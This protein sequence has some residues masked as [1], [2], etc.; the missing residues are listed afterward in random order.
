[1]R[2]LSAVITII[3][4]AW[5]GLCTQG[6][7]FL[8][9]HADVPLPVVTPR[10]RALHDAS[11]IIDLHADSLLMR[12]DLLARS[13]KGH[14]DLPRLHEGGVA[15]QVFAAPT[16]TPWNA[17]FD[18]TDGDAFDAIRLVGILQWTPLAWRRPLGRALWMAEKL[19]G[20][21]A[22]SGGE[23]AILE[24]RA[25][26]AALEARRARGET[27]VGAL[28]ALEGAHAAES[29]PENLERLFE[30]GY[31]MLAFTHFFDTDYA[32]S[33]HGIDKA[34]LTPLGRA[35]LRRMEALGMAVDLAH[36]SPAAIDDVL[37]LATRPVVV[38]HGGVQG[39]CPGPRTLSDAHVRGIAANGGVIGIGY[40]EGAV[41]GEEPRHVVEAV[42]YVIELVGDAHVALGSDYDGVT[43]MGFDTS[44]LRA[45]TQALLDAG[46]SDESLG[47]V[48]GG[49]AL[50]VLSQT[51]PVGSAGS[52]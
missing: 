6:E 10:A 41:C 27:V 24:T 40:F 44:E 21:E 17:N 13:S 26:L 31:R 16:V 37:A 30:A 46:M 23:L 29:L 15:L 47:R 3:A 32:G 25:D 35:T 8:N 14:V 38:S 5:I 36:L 28:L 4:V 33:A 19:R 51:L 45:L 20:F 11:F 7:R 12:R 1:M 22:A 49:N 48:L 34:G 39:T 18:R 42:L 9:R 50:R 43:R 52:P 2:R